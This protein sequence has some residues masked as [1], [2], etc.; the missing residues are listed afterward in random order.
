LDI[1]LKVERTLDTGLIKDVV[2]KM[3]DNVCEDGHSFDEWD[4]EPESCAW[5]T[6]GE[7]GLYSLHATNKTTLEMHAFIKPEH[8]KEY[9]DESGKAILKWI[10]IES[11]AQYKK[12]ITQVPKLYPNVKNFCLR[13]GFVLEGI[14]RLSHQ[15]NGELVDQWMFGIT[16][17]EIKEVLNEQN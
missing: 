7:C 9:S 3:W 15:K 17:D 14:N 13:H 1:S 10:L 4:P 5:L 12:I 16:R 2:S 11:P 8:R 6:V